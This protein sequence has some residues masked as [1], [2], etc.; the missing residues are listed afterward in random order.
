RR[1]S[2]G[3]IWSAIL[4]AVLRR[5]GLSAALATAALGALALPAL[6]LHTADSGISDF[7]RDMPVLQAYER[8][9]RAFP[10]GADPAVV[11]VRAADVRAADVTDAIAGFKARALATGQLYEPVT[12][13][14]NAAGTVSVIRLGLSGSG[15]DAA[16]EQ[17]IRTLRDD[18]VPATLSAVTGAEV[19]VTGSAAGSID[20]NQALSRSA[21]LVFAFVLGLAFVLLLVAFRSLVVAITSILLNLL[22]VAAAYGL[23]VLVFQDGWGERLLNF[24]STGTIVNWLPLFLFVILFGLSMDYHV[25]VLSRIRE[26]YDRG[27]PTR[28]AVA[29]GIQGT[30]GVITSAAVV[31]VAVFS[32]FMTMSLTSTK[33]MGL[34]LAAAVFIDATIVRAMLLPSVMA[35]LG[36]RNWYLPRWLSWLPRLS[37]GT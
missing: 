4:R 21:P 24:E 3:R 33:Q 16:S 11:V 37:H 30:A 28:T 8:I 25:F 31:M 19:A 12:V 20:F 14:T 2:D 22:S 6:G 32:L 1:R 15:T 18:V 10:G 36:E 13:E 7:P 35:L 23:L 27:L 26:G 29:R 17:A 34:G 9:Q 5:P